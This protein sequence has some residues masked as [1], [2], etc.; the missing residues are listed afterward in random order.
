MRGAPLIPSSSPTSSDGW[1]GKRTFPGNF[2]LRAICRR[3]ESHGSMTVMPAGMHHPGIWDAYGTWLAS[4]RGSASISARMATIGLP[5]RAQQPPRSVQL[6]SYPASQLFQG[7]RHAAQRCAFSWKPSSGCIWK[8][9]RHA[10]HLFLNGMSFIEH[11]SS[12][13]YET[14]FF[15]NEFILPILRPQTSS[16][17]Q[18][19]FLGCFQRRNLML[20]QNPFRLSLRP[21]DQADA[22]QHIPRLPMSNARP[23]G[24]DIPRQI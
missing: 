1:T 22:V 14:F 23:A 3:P 6:P 2:S 24:Q 17:H 9:R 19:A 11:N 21:F 20:V 8:S 13:S 4:W 16:R 12:A 18:L 5:F 15:M 7:F 10:T